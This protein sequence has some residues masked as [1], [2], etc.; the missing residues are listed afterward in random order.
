MFILKKFGQLL[1]TVILVTLFA[2]LLL[3]LLP[4]DPTEVLIPSGSDQQR[5]ELRQELKLDQ[6]FAVL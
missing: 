6:S 5:E 3:E 1:V 4:G 2:S